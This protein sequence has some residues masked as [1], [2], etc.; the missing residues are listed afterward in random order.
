MARFLL[1]G[2]LAAALSVAASW[3]GCSGDEFSTL[4]GGGDAASGAAGTGGG[5]A[6]S[7]G[8]GGASGGAAGGPAGG[9]GETG[10]DAGGSGG[11]AC[12]PGEKPC[13]PDCVS[14]DDPR[15]GCGEASCDACSLAHA[16]AG[17]SQG[18]CAIA[19]CETGYA[20]CDADPGTGCE[21]NVA[22][23]P[24]N[25]G[26]CFNECGVV[27]SGLW[28]CV[29]FDCRVS[30]CPE[31]KASCNA[32]PDCET[33]LG[34]LED[35]LF[36]GD[37]CVFAN[38]DASC[39]PVNGCKLLDCQEGFGNCDGVDNN[40]C[41]KT[42]AT[43]VSHCGACGHG[44]SGNNGIPQCLNGYCAPIC[45]PGWADC[46]QPLAPDPDD[47]C[48]TNAVTDP[49]HCGGCGRACGGANVLSLECSGGACT[50]S[51]VLGW[52]NCNPL[53][54]GGS[55]GD[56]GCETAVTADHSNCGG[57]GNTCPNGFTCANGRC[58]CGTAASVACGLG[59]C[60]AN[61][62]CSCGGTPCA[63]GE[64]CDNGGTACVCNGGSPCSQGKTCCSE[65]GCVNLTTDP[66]NCGACGHAC[67]EGFVCSG[68]TQ[69]KCEDAEDC[70]AADGACVSGKCVCN[71]VTCGYGQRCQ[72][73]GSCG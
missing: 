56:D 19:D 60:G 45:D 51:C 55:F 9:G 52:G 57:C 2:G 44:C 59:V 38:A 22:A 42:L 40:G 13:G 62:Q 18:S 32:T 54:P 11:A 31:G 53:D 50:S 61:G 30:Q 23:D 15:F 10:V 37:A 3:P 36:C 28:D 27:G 68:G 39:D 24:K 6:G 17:C 71:G 14:I 48:E 20:D 63:V 35:C 25:C 4:Q 16:D 47:G 29:D 66:D 64:I 49:F 58:S 72:P 41:E 69:C 5:S 21:T 46:E 34:T 1:A 12:G 73:D 70:L 33:T 7:G 67:P 26:S 65:D 43:S 8:A